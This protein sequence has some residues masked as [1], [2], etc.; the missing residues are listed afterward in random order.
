M[1]VNALIGKTVLIQDVTIIETLY[2]EFKKLSYV[3]PMNRFDKV[4]YVGKPLN[5][6]K[7]FLERNTHEFIC[8]TG[9]SDIDLM[10]RD[11]VYEY[12]QTT[13][14]LKPINKR[15]YELI[16]EFEDMEFYNL[17]KLYY[18]N[19]TLPSKYGS[20]RVSMYTLYKALTEG[21]R[22]S[23]DIYFQLSKVYPHKL[24][25]SSLLSFLD[26]VINL[27]LE[28]AKPA[29]RLLIKNTNSL[30]YDKIKTYAYTYYHSSR[31]PMDLFY[32]IMSLSSSY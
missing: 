2:P 32:F 3:T 12:L 31:G 14:N 19:G 26:R 10:S 1:E 20:I 6:L 11:K 8:T 13:Y 16:N 9:A 23:I 25:E 18:I 21:Q 29:Y 7:G 5:N 15:Q 28:G 17:M 22:R 27:N 4:I 24:I 30:L